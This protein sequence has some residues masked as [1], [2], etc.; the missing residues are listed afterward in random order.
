[1]TQIFISRFK[2]QIS[3]TLKQRLSDTFKLLQTVIKSTG[4]EVPVPPGSVKF[5]QSIRLSDL[6]LRICDSDF[7]I[8]NVHLSGFELDFLFRANERFIFR[9]FLSTLN[10]EHL[11]DLTLYTKVLYTDEDKVFE[12]KYVRYAEHLNRRNDM[13]SALDDVTCDGNF[14]FHLGQIHVTFL[15][16]LIV[17]LQRFIVNLEALPFMQKTVVFLHNKLTQATDT[18]TNS[19]KINLV[20]NMRGPVLMFPQKTSSPNVVIIDTGKNKKN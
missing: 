7:D 10:V 11:S 17:Q 5:S 18:L 2:K 1:M 12:V 13:A 4:K 14:K 20:I 8:V 16:K 6:N 9:S 15:Y 19:T 3:T